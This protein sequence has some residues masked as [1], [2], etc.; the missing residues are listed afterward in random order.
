MATESVQVLV[1]GGKATA[2]PPL[3]PSLGPLGVNIGQVVAEINRKTDAFK[4]MQVPVKVLVDKSSKEFTIEVG[5]PPAASLIKKE[6]GIDKGAGNPLQDKVGNLLIEQIIKISKMKE[7]ALSGKELKQ[8]M[9]EVM[10]TCRSM[11][12]LIEGVSV[13]EALEKMN[14][15]D[16]DKEIKAEKTELS[17]A[18]LKSLDE[19]RKHLQEELTRKRAEYE[20][21]AKELLVTL[22][23]KEPNQKRAKL[24][25]AKI[26]QQ[27]IDELVPPVK[28][29]A[30]PGAAGK[31]GK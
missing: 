28:K 1:Q 18:E 4:G 5:T 30:T 24:A 29:E 31:G 21:R 27:I 7:D 6:A 15:G 17:A 23:G 26:P 25:E 11:G 10:G 20:V 14:H 3:G 12:I 16:F 22:E 2:A 8:R 19:E 13:P 9:K